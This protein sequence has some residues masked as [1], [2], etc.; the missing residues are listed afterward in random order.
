MQKAFVYFRN[1]YLENFFNKKFKN[2]EF[3][4]LS[5][6]FYHFD[7]H[8]KLLSTVKLKGKKKRRIVK[9]NCKNERG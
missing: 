7:N 9:I 1:I 6:F 3:R 5:K 4:T 8:F 2:Y